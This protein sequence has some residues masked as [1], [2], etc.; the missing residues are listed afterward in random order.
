M[1]QH[2]VPVNVS[3]WCTCK[4]FRENPQ[5]LIP[6]WSYYIYTHGENTLNIVILSSCWL[7]RLFSYIVPPT[8]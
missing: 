3:A 5:H 4:C 2:G 6:V 7:F 1:F 8:L